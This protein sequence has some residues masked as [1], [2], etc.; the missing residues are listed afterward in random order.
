MNAHDLG[1]AA[2]HVKY[3]LA[4]REMRQLRLMKL[5]MANIDEKYLSSG[6]VSIAGACRTYETR[7]IQA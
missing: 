5:N 2:E 7:R 3:R 1:R 4:H 6:A